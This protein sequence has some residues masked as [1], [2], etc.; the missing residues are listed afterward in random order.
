MSQINP[1]ALVTVREYFA[2]EA[3]IRD[4]PSLANMEK[5]VQ[6]FPSC[7]IFWTS[8]LDF[9]LEN[10]EKAFKVAG[11]AVEGC[12]HI[13]L[14]RRYLSLGKSLFRLP[15]I[16][17]IYEKAV[18]EVGC[19][20]KAVDFWVEYLYLLRAIFNTQ[21]MAQFNLEDPA[22][23][24]LGSFLLPLSSNRPPGLTDDMVDLESIKSMSD[25]NMRPTIQSIREIF[26]NAL[27]VP[28]ERI[29]AVWDEYQ[30]FEQVIASAMTHIAQ[31][32]PVMPGMPPPPA[33]MASVQCSKLLSEYSNRW[34]QSKQALKSISR[35]YAPI[36][37]YF[38]P[39][40]LDASTAD[41]LRANVL[42]WR[43][44]IDWEK[45][46]PLKL[47]YARFQ[48]RM[49]TVFKQCLMSNVYVAEFW[50]DL[51]VSRL[52]ADGYIAGLSVLHQ[53]IDEYLVN[54]VMLRLVVALIHEETGD[55]EKAVEWLEQSLVYFETVAKKPVPS[56]LVHMLKLK[57]RCFGAVHARSTFLQ[58]LEKKS[59][60]LSHYG[61]FLTFARL[62][63]RAL[64]NKSNFRKVLELGIALF[65]RDSNA[66]S[67]LTSVLNEEEES[68]DSISLDQI[69]PPKI[70]ALDVDS[71]RKALQYG[72]MWPHSSGEEYD[73]GKS[74]AAQL[75]LIEID[76]DEAVI[77]GTPLRPDTSR[78]SSY[79]PGLEYDSP[80]GPEGTAGGSSSS[81]G[82]DRL[83]S[84]PA[85]L[86][87][88][89]HILPRCE[90]GSVAETDS[91]LKALQTMDLPALSVASMK[92]LRFEEDPTVD[93]IRRERDAAASALV[94]FG[95]DNSAGSLK[96]LIL[97]H[98]EKSGNEQ[99]GFLHHIKSDGIA[100]DDK[101]GQRDFLSALAAN[102]HRER[103]N[104]KRHKL[105][106]PLV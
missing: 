91:I 27:C 70:L 41:V 92:L 72:N 58:F 43:R 44:V 39:I 100:D 36:N 51:F 74:P 73:V 9:L 105:L 33:A 67:A 63:Q 78:M 40:P 32:M 83:R 88:L 59:M 42:G 50:F 94:G 19:D 69:S 106:T 89:V 7:A 29:D 71:A 64:C 97:P 17:P 1:K 8:Y 86:K 37:M 55:A 104:Y 95:G 79:K 53:A 10:P 65:A 23:L 54:D 48:S 62:E 6:L 103:I 82:E 52:S 101:G 22:L 47:N 14:W 84:V 3:L 56:L 45:S 11:R 18:V 93:R 102:I 80:D 96:R 28:M 77:A 61:V 15:Q 85:S 90:P 46:N 13:D 76:A 38:A 5:A 12:P 49:A 68:G 98:E 66:V 2:M 99:F 24:P 31:S 20:P 81:N 16:F 60:H 34:I 87:T 26:Q 30:A 57:L 21:L 75:D 4:R 25:A 35:I